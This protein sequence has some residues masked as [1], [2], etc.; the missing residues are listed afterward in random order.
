MAHFIQWLTISLNKLKIKKIGQD[1]FNIQ[2][3]NCPPCSHGRGS[4]PF[5]LRLPDPDPT[6]NNGYIKLFL[7]EQN[8]LNRINKFKL[9][10]MV[11]KI[12]FYVYLPKISIFFFISN[13]ASAEPDPRKTNSDPHLCISQKRFF[14]MARP[15]RP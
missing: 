1:F 14:L 4:D 11:Y 10:M 13:Q 6:C 8:I 15:L 5:I 7:F 9:Q 12:E 2:Y 3:H